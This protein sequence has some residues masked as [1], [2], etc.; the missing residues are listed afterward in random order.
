MPDGWEMRRGSEEL[1]T[2]AIEKRKTLTGGFA[3]RHPS[4]S[5]EATPRR[6][7]RVLLLVLLCAA[8]A[9]AQGMFL[10]PATAQSASCTTN[11]QCPP[12]KLCC[13]ACG[14]IGC[15]AMACLTPLHGRCPAIP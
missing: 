11:A 2:G 9:L 5:P 7:S 10:A 14:F 6:R 1:R 3:M 13:R 8:I 15:T 4:A 12:G